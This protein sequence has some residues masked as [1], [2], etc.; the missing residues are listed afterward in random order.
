MLE[1]ARRRQ[2][3]VRRADRPGDLGWMV[4]AHGELYEQQFGWN[5]DFEALV[6][7][8]VAD[9]AA[10][11]SSAA[12]AAWIAEADGERVGCVMLVAGDDQ[13]GVAKLRVLLV[14]SHARGL[15]MGTRLVEEALVFAR[16]AGY[17]SV[18]LWTT[19]N[20]ASARRIYQRFGFI[21]TDEKP[22]RGFGH[23][24]VGQTWTLDLLDG[25][26]E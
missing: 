2:I 23:D 10:K 20:L 17:R 11:R 24:L 26:A 25:P 16:G 4:M 15:G 19:D 22:H 21:L 3:L 13:P 18:T 14:T 6:A 8:I 12:E 5:A 1:G 9:Y 7:R